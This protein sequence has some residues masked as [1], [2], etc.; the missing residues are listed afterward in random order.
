[1]Q[2]IQLEN[3]TV[4]DDLGEGP[5]VFGGAKSTRAAVCSLPLFGRS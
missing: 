4:R 5:I 3:V 2:N 1:L